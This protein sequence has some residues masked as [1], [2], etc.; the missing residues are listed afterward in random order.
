MGFS[1]GNLVQRRLC[2]LYITVAK[3]SLFLSFFLWTECETPEEEDVEVHPDRVALF[4]DADGLQDARVP[5]LIA[6]QLVLKHGSLLRENK[7]QQKTG[8][9]AFTRKHVCVSSV[10]T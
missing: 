6:D 2:I 3:R 4:A 1:R 10:E 9:S 8:M 5:Q 7:K